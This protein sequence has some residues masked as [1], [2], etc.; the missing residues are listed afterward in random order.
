MSVIYG[1]VFS[2]NDFSPLIYSPNMWLDASDSNTLYDSTV[3]GNIVTNGGLVARWEDKSGNGRHATQSTSTRAPRLSTNQVNNRN[4]IL[5]TNSG[6]PN[7]DTFMDAGI[8]P[9]TMT[10]NHSLFA[11]VKCMGPS[12]NLGTEVAQGIFLREGFHKGMLLR[13]TANQF[14]STVEAATWST[15]SSNFSISIP[16]DSTKVIVAGY[17]MALTP[18][19]RMTLRTNKNTIISNSSITNIDNNG[20]VRIGR[21]RS[22]NTNNNFNWPFN[23]YICELLYF[24]RSLSNIEFA[25]LEY[26]LSKK[27]GGS[28]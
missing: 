4:A 19:A 2:V 28:V 9:S 1:Q 10:A 12:L 14:P 25:K 3:G 13:G 11:V 22:T 17:S 15:T 27:W 5:F 16:I 8:T 20:S 18:T 7:T 6:Y 23:G 26:Y 24:T 21:A